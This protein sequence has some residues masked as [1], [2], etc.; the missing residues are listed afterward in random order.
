MSGADILDPEVYV[1]S[2]LLQG[3]IPF[4][5][6]PGKPGNIS[7]PSA[8]VE[9]RQQQIALAN[10]RRQKSNGTKTSHHVVKWGLLSSAFLKETKM[11]DSVSAQ[12][13]EQGRSKAR[14]RRYGEALEDLNQAISANPDFPKAYIARG[15]VQR[16]LG[17][18]N[19]AYKDFEQAA[20]IY[21][22]RGDL[23]DANLLQKAIEDTR[24]KLTQQ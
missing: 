17:N 13:Y 4:P 10:L 22:S 21:R 14:A 11:P 6:G 24:K 7:N 12:A 23:K 3:L 9:S 19:E 20:S 1:E 16:L 8:A 5:I 2:F 15:H 18:Y